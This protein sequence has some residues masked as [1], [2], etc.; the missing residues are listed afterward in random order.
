MGWMKRWSEAVVRVFKRV[1]S[2]GYRRFPPPNIKVVDQEGEKKIREARDAAQAIRCRME[3]LEDRMRDIV[4]QRNRPH[5]F[6]D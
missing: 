4:D 1:T 6:P 3:G 5:H 2:I